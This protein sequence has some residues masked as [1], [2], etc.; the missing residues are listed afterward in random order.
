MSSNRVPNLSESQNNS[1]TVR[2]R[3]FYIIF[4]ATV[5]NTSAEEVI[6]NWVE[7]DINTFPAKAIEIAKY[8]DSIRGQLEQKIVEKT[9]RNSINSIPKVDL[10]IIFTYLT[11][12]EMERDL[13]RLK[14]EI[15]KFAD[16]FGAT[17]KS[18]DFCY[19]VLNNCTTELP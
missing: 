9:S 3:A 19:A 18:A 8:W 17:Q 12:Y 5:R 15:T 10:A 16:E 11:S 13:T 14:N 7:A 4:A 1:K 6:N 2:K